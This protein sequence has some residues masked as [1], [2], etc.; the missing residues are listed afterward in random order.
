MSVK[1]LVY[2]AGTGT[3]AQRP[4]PDE[5]LEVKKPVTR[6]LPGPNLNKARKLFSRLN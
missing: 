5:K 3:L 4:T 6:Y 2:R 1:Y